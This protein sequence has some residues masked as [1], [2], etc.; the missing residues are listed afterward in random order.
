[1]RGAVYELKAPRNAQGH[2]Q[3]GTRYAVIVQSDDLPLS[4]CLVAPTSTSARH[5]AF[6]PAVE[7]GGVTTYVM[8]EQTTTIDPERRLGAR[9]GYLLAAEMAAV[10]VALR[11]VLGLT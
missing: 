10:D 1:M 4:T 7:I 2:E 5:T 8:V 11:E 3:R 9:V 6:R